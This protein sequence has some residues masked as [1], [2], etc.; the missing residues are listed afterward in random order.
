[1]PAEGVSGLFARILRGSE[2]VG[3]LFARILRGFLYGTSNLL[4]FYEVFCMVHPK[5]RVL[6][7][8]H[9]EA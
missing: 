3:G 6:Y 4:V 2:G 5:T 9:W 1:M 8:G 7:V